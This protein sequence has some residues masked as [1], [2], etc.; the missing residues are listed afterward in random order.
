M[1]LR[2]K[3][4]GCQ[5]KNPLSLRVCPA[6]GRSLDN[7]PPEQRVYVIEPLEALAPQPSPPQA[8][9]QAAATPAPASVTAAQEPKKAKRPRKK[10]S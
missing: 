1:G 2:L 3:C 5:A 10:K 9:P 7:L 6:C 8:L 4:P